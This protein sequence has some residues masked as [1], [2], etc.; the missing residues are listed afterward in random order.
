MMQVQ[1][2]GTNLAQNRPSKLLSGN[3]DD[4]GST[5]AGSSDRESDSPRRTLTHKSESAGEDGAAALVYLMSVLSCAQEQPVHTK[6]RSARAM[7]TPQKFQH[8]P[9]SNQISPLPGF[10]GFSPPP[11]LAAVVVPVGFSPPPGLSLPPAPPPGLAQE[12]AAPVVVEPFNPKAFH[13]ELVAIFRELSQSANVAAAVRRVRAQKVPQ[14]HQANEITDILTR[15]AEEC[16][17]THRRLFFAFTAGLAKGGTFE[18]SEV[19]SG[20]KAFFADVYQ[21]LCEEVPR[22]PS[23]VE[24]ELVPTLRE[25]F[26]AG[27]LDRSLPARFRVS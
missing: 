20:I 2:P 15:A 9:M 4:D 10:D 26:S 22:L 16:R 21:D 25:V 11:G 19:L 27:I 18:N 3:V 17:G 7:R 24:A 6:A 8:Q 12:T 5:S 1:A 13:R 14:S 23:I